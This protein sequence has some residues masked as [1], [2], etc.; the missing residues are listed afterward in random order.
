MTY[1]IARTSAQLFAVIAMMSMS[2]D[3]GIT[4]ELEQFADAVGLVCRRKASPY[5]VAG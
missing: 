4:P 1:E 2:V 3:D 5:S